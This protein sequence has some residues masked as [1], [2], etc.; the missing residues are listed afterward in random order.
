MR[1]ST[2][3]VSVSMTV[4]SDTDGVRKATNR[5]RLLVTK[6]CDPSGD[7]DSDQGLRLADRR[8]ISFK[9]LGVDDRDAVGRGV[10]HVEVL[11]LAVGQHAVR[12]VARQRAW[13]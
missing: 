4:T 12:L 5:E 6:I 1:S 9:R 7:S 8:L 2:T 10:Q 3:A 13:R 11:P